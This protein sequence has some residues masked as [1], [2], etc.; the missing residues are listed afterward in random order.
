M[1]IQLKEGSEVLRQ[2]PLA[3]QGQV[4][5]SKNNEMEL[6]AVVKGLEKLVE[7][8]PVSIISDSRYV[9]DSATSLDRWKA[10]GWRNSS[11]E[12][13]NLQLWQQ[14]DQLSQG[15][16]L[17]LVWQRGHVGHD[18]NEM[19]NTLASNAAL[20]MYLAGEKAIRKKHPTWFK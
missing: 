20:G 12:V 3:G 18:L 7:S 17:E 1:I 10:A 5:I 9:I 15:R 2:R 14:F 11:G 6:T 16:E 4:M 13:K 8:L 19:A